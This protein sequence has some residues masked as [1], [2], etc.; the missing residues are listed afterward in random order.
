MT[1]GAL[2]KI[3]PMILNIEFIFEKMLTSLRK[4]PKFSIYS[5]FSTRVKTMFGKL[6][7][8]SSRNAV[9]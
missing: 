2:F 5:D 3:D 4:M 1:F 6:D 9:L 7:K 8:V